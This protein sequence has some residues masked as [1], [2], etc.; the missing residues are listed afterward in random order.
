ML[1][2]PADVLL[3]RYLGDG[4]PSGSAAE[5]EA[6]LRACIV[7]CQRLEQIESE[8]CRWRADYAVLTSSA[9]HSKVLELPTPVTDCITPIFSRCQTR[10]HDFV[11]W[12]AVAAVLA[13]G[14]VPP[15]CLLA[16]RSK[17]SEP[18]RAYWMQ[19]APRQTAAVA[20]HDNME[21]SVL[22]VKCWTPTHA[23]DHLRRVPRTRSSTPSQTRPPRQ[24]APPIILRTVVIRQPVL[25]PPPR[26]ATMP[27][28]PVL[29]PQQ[30][31]VV[32]PRPSPR[33]IKA[34]TSPFRSIGK[35][36]ASQPSLTPHGL[37]G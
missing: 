22:T 7:C 13:F 12:K 20:V 25:E 31:A 36:F 26:I 21:D 17:S 16:V 8:V 11:T 23:D 5:L 19:P 9:R 10:W 6:H 4:L 37:H 34:L 33:I 27:V 3:E 14:V 28:R 2:H 32:P 1:R 30:A 29:I 35:L 24:V 18:T 15:L